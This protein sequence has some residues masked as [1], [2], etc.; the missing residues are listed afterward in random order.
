MVDPLWDEKIRI[1]NEIID[2]DSKVLDV[3]CGDGHVL[4]RIKGKEKLGLDISAQY[5][6]ICRKSGLK[7][8]KQDLNHTIKIKDK[9][10]DVIICFEVLEHVY[11]IK[12]LAKELNRILKDCGYL[13]VTVPHHSNFKSLVI[14]LFGMFDHHFSPLT[15]GS[16][17]DDFPGLGI[18]HG[19]HINFFS[20]K[21]VTELF[22]FKELKL[23]KTVKMGRNRLLPMSIFLAY[24]KNNPKT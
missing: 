22:Y 9:S 3:G 15:D 6:K 4:K 21:T 23:I 19:R 13:F 14:S 17:D 2:K 7:V 11:E 24:K 12:Q 16:G 18:K 1:I 10:F 8:R 5:L 20:E